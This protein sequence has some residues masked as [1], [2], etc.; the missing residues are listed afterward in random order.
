MQRFKVGDRVRIVAGFSGN[1]F[2]GISC[3]AAMD[4]LGREGTIVNI[5]EANKVYAQV[6]VVHVPNAVIPT[7]FHVTATPDDIEC[8]PEWL[9]P[10]LRDPGRQVVSWKEC[11][12]MPEH[13]R[14]E[15]LVQ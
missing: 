15:E 3:P 13:L 12:W 4:N 9:E 10:I 11:P 2:T 1:L 14:E 7:N 5:R 8:L 6:C